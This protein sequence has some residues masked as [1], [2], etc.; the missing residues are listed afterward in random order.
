MNYKWKYETPSGFSDIWMRSDGQI[1]TGLWFEGSRDQR[2][3]GMVCEERE[4]PIFEETVRWLDVFFSGRQ[5]DFTPEYRID[6]LTEFR[7]DVMECMLEIPWGETVTY[8]EIAARLAEQRCIA[9]MSAQAVGGAVGWN[10]I[11]LIIP[12]HRVVGADG[13]L[14]GYGGG[15]ENKKALLELEKSTPFR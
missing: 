8:G 6:G 9:R 11:C 3:H 10:P 15:L 12:C 5:P 13:S 2:K 4:L 14:T 7:R 1:L